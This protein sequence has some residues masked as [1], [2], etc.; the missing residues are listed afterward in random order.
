M[1]AIMAEAGYTSAE[2]CRLVG[3][4]YRQLDYWDRTGLL[5]PSV[6]PARG[7]GYGRRYDADDVLVLRVIGELRRIGVTVKSPIMARAV[8]VLAAA[9]PGIA[10][11]ALLVAGDTVRLIP[12]DLSLPRDRPYSLVP[13][14]PLRGDCHTPVV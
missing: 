9:P 12:D 11:M 5:T 4:T 14:D 8:A 7:S 13:L 6:A 10:G 2:V 1:T 3:I